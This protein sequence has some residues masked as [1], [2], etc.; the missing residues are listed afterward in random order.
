MSGSAH[1]HWTRR[2]FLKASLASA[3]LLVG[4]P[5]YAEDLIVPSIPD[6]RLA[7]YNTHTGERLAVTY[8]DSSGQYDQDALNALNHLLRCH[9]T[10]RATKMDVQ[11][12]EFVNAVDKRL[13]GDNEIHIISGFRSSEYHRL[14]RTKGRRVARH[15]LHLS[16]KAIDLRIP[17]IGPNVIRKAALDLRNGGVGYY[18][19]RGFVHLDSGAFRY[20]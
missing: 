15:S 12:I 19:R 1:H 3:F 6:G 7:L 4:K 11:V 16:G 8:R 14:L 13:G 20:W 9:Y 2:S 18:P 5:A 17:G 10:N